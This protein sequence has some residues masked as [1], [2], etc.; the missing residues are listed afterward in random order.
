M[1]TIKREF[2]M[3]KIVVFNKATHWLFG[4]VDLA[5]LNA[6]ITEIENDGWQVIS[7]SANTHFFGGIVSYTLLIES[8]DTTADS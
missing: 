5:L 6:Q 1:R 7:V 8:L 2:L 3:R 4:S